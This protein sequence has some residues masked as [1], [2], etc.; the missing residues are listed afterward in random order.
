MWR[1]AS[2][3]FKMS[4][5][6]SANV[7]NQSAI[8]ASV[9]SAMGSDAVDHQSMRASAERLDEVVMSDATGTVG[10]I[11]IEQKDGIVVL[12]YVGCS[13]IVVPC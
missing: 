1:A 9:N 7:R 8:E 10:L 6:A 4:Q 12:M 5:Y 13:R 11:F 3:S 2:A